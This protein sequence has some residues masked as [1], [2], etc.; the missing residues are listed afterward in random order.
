MVQQ[1]K[2][3]KQNMKVGLINCAFQNKEGCV[4]LNSAQ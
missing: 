2:I 3:T 1:N 4:T